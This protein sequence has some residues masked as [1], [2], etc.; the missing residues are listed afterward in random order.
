MIKFQYYHTHFLLPLFFRFL[1]DIKK[2]VLQN[3]SFGVFL[4][5]QFSLVRLHRDTQALL[6]CTW[7]TESIS[8]SDLVSKN[9]V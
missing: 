1:I 2:S 6:E 9:I 7:L 8:E 4:I 3:L 5:P